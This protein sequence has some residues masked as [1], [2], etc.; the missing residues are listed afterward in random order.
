MRSG[1]SGRNRAQA[2]IARDRGCGVRDWQRDFLDGR[3][4]KIG[5][6]HGDVACFSFHPR[7]VIST[8]DG[9]MITTANPEW[10]RKFRLLR[11]HAMSV[12]IQCVTHQTA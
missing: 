3:W 5:K 2:S 1:K 10:D 11:Q 8:G 6:P 12:P 7:K 9:G 4:E